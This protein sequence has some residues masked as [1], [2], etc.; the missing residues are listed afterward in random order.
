MPDQGRYDPDFVQFVLSEHGIGSNLG[1]ALNEVLRPLFGRIEGLEQSQSL[2]Q[3]ALIIL[4]GWKGTFDSRL[5]H[6]EKVDGNPGP[7]VA[8]LQRRNEK[9]EDDI[10]DLK[11]IIDG[12]E[13]GDE[14][15]DVTE[16]DKLHEKLFREIEKLRELA[17]I[18]RA[19]IAR[20]APYLANHGILPATDEE[21][22]RATVLRAELGIE[23]ETS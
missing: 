7:D 2:T 18:Y 11:T 22:A 20:A 5:R 15:E 13:A 14:S 9:L 21:V 4:Q 23:E 10:Q 16:I 17:A 6:L 1:A 19:V 8:L 3:D 12:L